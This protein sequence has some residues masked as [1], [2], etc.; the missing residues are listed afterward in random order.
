DTSRW[1]GSARRAIRRG[2]PARVALTAGLAI[3]AGLPTWPP[4]AGPPACRTSA[5]GTAGTRTP[6]SET[7]DGGAVHAPTTGARRAPGPAAGRPGRDHVRRRAGA[8]CGDRGPGPVPG[9]EAHRGPDRC[10][11]R[12]AGAIAG[13]RGRVAGPTMAA[14]RTASRTTRRGLAEWRAAGPSL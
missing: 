7:A 14:G 3:P 12:R 10:A 2:F 9:R 4:A 8:A 6:G 5:R 11:G 1:P 13:Q